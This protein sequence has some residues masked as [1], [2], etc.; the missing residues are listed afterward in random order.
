M[1][2][3]SMIVVLA[4]VSLLISVLPTMALSPVS[5]VQV[6]ISASATT[7]NV[8]LNWDQVT[9]GTTG[10]SVKYQ[11]AK[12]IDGGKNY[13]VLQAFD[14]GTTYTDNGVPN[15]T[16]ITYK[17]TVQE[18]D[19]LNNVVGTEDKL[20]NVYPPDTNA[21]ANF[22]TNTNVCQQCHQT[23]TAQGAKLLK[24]ATTL[25]MC[26]TC[27]WGTGN[28]SK[29]NVKDG[30]TSTLT[31]KSPSLGGPMEHTAI[32]GDQWGN[33]NTSSAHNFDPSV[34]TTA[35][36]GYN[37][38][39]N[40]TCTSCHGA[41][42]TGNYRQI[43]NVITYPTGPTTTGTTS[44]TFTAA[45][46]TLSGSTAGETATYISGSVS[47]CGSCHNDYDTS[48][49]VQSGQT[50]SGTYQQMYRH[51]VGVT[52]ASYMDAS[53]SSLPLTT[54]LPLEGTNVAANQNT[55]VCLTC[56]YAHGTVAD[57]T[58]NSSVVGN[59]PS[60]MLKRQDFMGV[61]EDCHK[62]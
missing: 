31:G 11:V 33:K 46:A 56:H 59:P 4:L 16:D 43:K 29:Y 20:T 9:P 42:E 53:G 18:T 26:Q 60:T 55:I 10:N 17:V 51:A 49:V 32:T 13:T 61:C 8:T 24:A 28:S 3:L 47:L 57:G 5:K 2:K 39:Q 30:E 25:A 44:V 23:H 7:S 34:A 21:H 40:L 14:T 6:T 19:A 37:A 12:S 62:K 54:T 35:P 1:K 38:S 58:E 50:L 27:H 45:A 48:G 22:S 36:G 41:H 15:Y 52:P